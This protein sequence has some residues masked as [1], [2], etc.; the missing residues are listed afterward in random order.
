MRQ[1]FTFYRSF[2]LAI[3]KMKKQDAATLVLAICAYALDGEEPK[4]SDNLSGTFELIRPTLDAS[5]RKSEN[6]KNGG[7]K[8]KQTEANASKTEATASEGKAEARG[9]LKR[10][11][12]REQGETASEKERE[13]E[14]EKEVEKEVEVEKE[15]YIPLSSSTEEDSPG[16][17]TGEKKA[18]FWHDPDLADVALAYQQGYGDIISTGAMMDIRDKY[19]PRFGK[20]IMLYA[21]NITLDNGKRSWAYTR[22]ILDRWAAEKITSIDQIKAKDGK[23]NGKK[24][25]EEEKRQIE[26]MKGY[27]SVLDDVLEKL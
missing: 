19:F 16:G 10:E 12:E 14:V 17:G 2:Y 27:F 18:N 25:A 11:R 7:S 1:Q 13:V 6:G 23:K 20:E 5:A 21:L 15:S 4:L 3:Q 24:T 26:T 9:N 22:A 8:R